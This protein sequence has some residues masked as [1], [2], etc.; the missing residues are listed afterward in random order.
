MLATLFAL[1]LVGA[2]TSLSTP[3]IGKAFIDAV[4]ERKDYDVIPIIAAALVVLALADVIFGFLSRL[5]HTKLSADIL[6]E[7]R[8]RLFRHALSAF[9]PCCR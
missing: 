6:V 8:Q 1:G 5:V 2:A 4:V 3:L 9:C 7:I